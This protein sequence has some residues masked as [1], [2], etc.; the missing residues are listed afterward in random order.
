MARAVVC[1]ACGKPI[2]GTYI[3]ALNHVWHPEHFCCACCT[4]PI[5]TD[6]FYVHDGAPYHEGCFRASRATSCAYC[7][8]MLLGPCMEDEWGA[9]YCV[10]HGPHLPRCCFCGR[11][12][13]QRHEHAPDEGERLI[14]RTCRSSAIDSDAQARPLFRQVMHWAAGQGLTFNSPVPRL[15]LSEPAHLSAL[16]R[17][18]GG[19]ELGATL[20][21]TYQRSQAEVQ[22]IVDG[23]AI[24]RGVPSIVFEGTLAHELGHVWLIAQAVQGWPPSDEEGFCQLLAYRYY[25]QVSTDDSRH[26]ARQIERNADAIYG[27]GFRRVRAMADAVGFHHLLRIIVSTKRLPRAR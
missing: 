24:L 15:H 25:S 1:K 8:R 18:P 22:R 4:R 13:R 2:A 12:A 10:E 5:T 3:A 17:A 19:Q 26:Q 6:R 11:L 20:A 9:H 21:T 7:G 16:G 27:E 14:C 23:V